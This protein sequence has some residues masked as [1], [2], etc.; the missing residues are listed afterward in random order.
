LAINT[1]SVSNSRTHGRRRSNNGG[2]PL[3]ILPFGHKRLDYFYSYINSKLKL[4]DFQ[5][6]QKSS[7]SSADPSDGSSLSVMYS[8][9]YWSKILQHRF[10]LLRPPGFDDRMFLMPSHQTP[11]RLITFGKQQRLRASEPCPSREGSRRRHDIT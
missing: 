8:K 7:S 10:Q 5:N 11:H 6:Y 3:L 2:G 4:K 9:K 1:E